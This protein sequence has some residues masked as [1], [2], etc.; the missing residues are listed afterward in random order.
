MGKKSVRNTLINNCKKYFQ[1]PVKVVNT[2]QPSVISFVNIKLH[3]E[4]LPTIKINLFWLK[5]LKQKQKLF[6]IR[7]C[8]KYRK[9]FMGL[10]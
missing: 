9:R 10:Q 3:M 7:F 4:V 5:Y 6:Y 8:M 2:Q 1:Y